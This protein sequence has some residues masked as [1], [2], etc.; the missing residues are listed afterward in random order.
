MEVEYFNKGDNARMVKIV[1]P[2]GSVEYFDLDAAVPE[3]ITVI[4]EL[5]RQAQQRAVFAEE[6]VATGLDTAVDLIN[7]T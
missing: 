4:L 5:D 3:H 6:A 2:D 7:N 1:S